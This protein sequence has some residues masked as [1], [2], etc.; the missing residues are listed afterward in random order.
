MSSDY[1][2]RG[3]LQYYQKNYSTYMKRWAMA[4]VHKLLRSIA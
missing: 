2:I 1:E 3:I 4:G